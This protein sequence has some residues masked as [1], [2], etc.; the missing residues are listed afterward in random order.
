MWPLPIILIT[1]ITPITPI[2]KN[3]SSYKKNGHVPKGV[4][5]QQSKNH[6]L[7]KEYLPFYIYR[8]YAPALLGLFGALWELSQVKQCATLKTFPKSRINP[9]CR[10]IQIVTL[11]IC[12]GAVTAPCCLRLRGNASLQT[13]DSCYPRRGVVALQ[14]RSVVV[15]P[16]R[17]NGKGPLYRFVVS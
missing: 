7:Q 5:D 14:R 4:A 17:T 13:T 3:L 10:V 9:N 16:R 2:Q 11:F 1:L 8:S 15:T 12:V 6:I